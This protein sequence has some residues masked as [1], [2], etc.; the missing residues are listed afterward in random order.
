V[1]IFDLDHRVNIV[2]KEIDLV[3]K[4][5]LVVLFLINID[6]IVG[7][8][9]LRIFSRKVYLWCVIGFLLILVLL[10]VVGFVWSNELQKNLSDKPNI[11][12]LVVDASSS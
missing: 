9:W 4:A 5:S 1:N 11:L 7:E 2:W 10:N 12:I 6:L 8:Q 3:M